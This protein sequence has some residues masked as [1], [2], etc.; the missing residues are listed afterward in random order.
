MT[1]ESVVQVARGSDAEASGT[2]WPIHEVGRNPDIFPPEPA[3][4]SRRIRRWP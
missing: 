2:S 4:C 3:G 1:Y